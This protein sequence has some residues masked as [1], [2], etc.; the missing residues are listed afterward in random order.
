MTHYALAKVDCC[1]YYISIGETEQCG[2]LLNLLIHAGIATTNADYLVTYDTKTQKFIVVSH[3]TLPRTTLDFTQ[4]LKV[5]KHVLKHVYIQRVHIERNDIPGKPLLTLTDCEQD[6][7]WTY[8]A[9]T[10]LR[11]VIGHLKDFPNATAEYIA[12]NKPI[13]SLQLQQFPQL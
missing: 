6:S 12:T 13:I 9:K 10:M 4:V 8:L 2:Q 3:L 5:F 1:H 11:V 7:V